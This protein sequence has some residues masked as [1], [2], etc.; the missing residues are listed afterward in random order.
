MIFY[1]IINFVE[2]VTLI[3]DFM[4]FPTCTSHFPHFENKYLRPAECIRWCVTV[5]WSIS[6]WTL[7]NVFSMVNSGAAANNF[8][9]MCKL[10][11]IIV[12]LCENEIIL[13]R[14][15][16]KQR[17]FCLQGFCAVLLFVCCLR[18][19]FICINKQ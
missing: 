2:K 17:P 19:T 5:Q 10:C 12:K 8:I 7:T 14:S 9:S 13:S 16:Y 4:L 18:R 1:Y 6:G 11:I 3:P 15:F